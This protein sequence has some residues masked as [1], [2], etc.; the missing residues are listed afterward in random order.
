VK[1][2]T[3]DEAGVLGETD[4]AVRIMSGQLG[5][6]QRPGD[7]AGIVIGGAERPEDIL[8]SSLQLGWRAG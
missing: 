2:P 3:V 7:L 1:D 5:V 6:Y 4:E 8:C